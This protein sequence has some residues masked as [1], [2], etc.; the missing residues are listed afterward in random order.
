MS[1]NLVSHPKAAIYTEG[2][3]EQ[4][5]VG[6]IYHLEDLSIYEHIILKQI[7]NRI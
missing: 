7:L 5:V 1:W 6:N 2:V 4:G 3:R